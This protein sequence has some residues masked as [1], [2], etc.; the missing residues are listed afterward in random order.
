MSVCFEWL[1]ITVENSV[2]LLIMMDS[3]HPPHLI[4]QH[5]ILCPTKVHKYIHRDGYVGRQVAS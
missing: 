5:L 1:L 4:L 3:F 2:F